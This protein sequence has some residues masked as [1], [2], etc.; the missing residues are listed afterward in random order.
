MKQL[1]GSRYKQYPP[2]KFDVADYYQ[3]PESVL[4]RAPCIVPLVDHASHARR[5]DGIL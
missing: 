2:V 5:R 4:R 1:W 3:K